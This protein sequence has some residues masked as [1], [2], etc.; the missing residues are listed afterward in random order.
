MSGIRS[1]SAIPPVAGS[2]QSTSGPEQ[3]SPV[4]PTQPAG[5]QT[6]SPP[7]SSSSSPNTPAPPD[8]TPQI[9][10]VHAVATAKTADNNVILHTEHGN[11]RLTTQS[12]VT[13]G[14]HIIFEIDT[15]EDITLARLISMDGKMFTPSIAARLVPIVNKLTSGTEGYVRAGQLHPLELQS[16]FQNLSATIG[17]RIAAAPPF[18]APPSLALP[19]APQLSISDQPADGARAQQ[20]LPPIAPTG[21]HPQNLAPETRRLSSLPAPY[22]ALSPPQFGPPSTAKIAMSPEMQQAHLARYHVV[23]AVFHR[24][25]PAV[26]AG[27]MLG[28]ANVTEG[29]KLQLIVQPINTSA[30][31]AGPTQRPDI[32]TGKV[33]AVTQPQTDGGRQQVHVS[34]PLGSFSYK[35]A[36]PPQNGAT[37]QFA[38]ADKITIFPLPYTDVQQPGPRQ[39]LV[40]LM[41]DWQNLR[42]ALNIVAHQEPAIA[43]SVLSTVM[44]QANSQLTGSLLFFMT[45]LQIGSVEKW[46]GQDF[47]LALKAAGRTSLLQA[48]DDDFS[49]LG[50]LQAEP[51]GQDWKSLNF[52]FF[53][54]SN[55]R[56]IRL[57][58][59]QQR[60]PDDPDG[61]K[62]STR[63]VIELNLTQTGP[64]QLDGVFGQQKF[65]LILRSNT[66]IPDHM[67]H[68][69]LKIFTANID[70]TGIQGQLTFKSVSP[71]PVDP[72]H[73]WEA[74]PAA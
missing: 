22:A 3:V 1:T 42:Q 63:F 5:Q 29:S 25:N 46:L 48:L 40:G 14:S 56:Q 62:D 18:L 17:G 67:K 73:E 19:P 28:V 66:V 24:P 8:G 33:I 70:I 55:V 16:G 58:Y 2:T 49:N 45:A 38:A 57:F 71:F 52:P 53:D 11:F 61:K 4:P 7:S 13:V 50:R 54:G 51:G 65:D 74:N 69:I 68:D 47:K 35:T 20:A 72:L 26:N 37:V 41:G 34:S 21:T 30:A 59:R 32:F 10:L 12:P 23:D 43:Q 15:V 44:P 39:P 64:I 6:G 31:S 36:T 27:Q 9:V 60:A